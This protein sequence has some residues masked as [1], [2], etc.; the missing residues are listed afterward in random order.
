MKLTHVPPKYKKGK[1][2]FIN[3]REVVRLDDNTILS[4]EYESSGIKTLYSLPHNPRYKPY[5]PKHNINLD[6]IPDKNVV[7]QYWSIY[8]KNDV[9]EGIIKDDKFIIK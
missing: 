1:I 9:V 7:L 4:L 3:D 8:K 6:T 5:S 2:D